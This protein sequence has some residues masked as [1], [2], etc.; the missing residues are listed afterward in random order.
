M[1]LCWRWKG[2]CYEPTVSRFFIRDFLHYFLRLTRL[3]LSWRLKPVTFHVHKLIHDILRIY[4]PVKGKKK[5]EIFTG[6]ILNLL[7]FLKVSSLLLRK[8]LWRSLPLAHIYSVTRRSP[9]H[10]SNLHIN[11]GDLL[12]VTPLDSPFLLPFSKRIIFQRN[13]DNF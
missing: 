6:L 7:W 8:F 3:S 10:G 12:M 9:I 13:G 11:D 2:L 1:K 5:E 4:N